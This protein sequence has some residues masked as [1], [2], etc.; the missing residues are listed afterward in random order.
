MK[1]HSVA[2]RTVWWKYFYP[3]SASVLLIAVSGSIWLCLAGESFFSLT[4]RLP[5]EVLV[6]EGW[7]GQDGARAAATE[8]KDGGYQYIVATGG[9]SEEELGNSNYAEMAEQALIALGVPK[10]RIIAAPI[11]PVERQRTFTSAVA[12]WQALEGKRV[13]PA[14]LNVFT[15]GPHAR[16]SRLIYAKVCRPG[17]QVGVIAFVPPSY[18]AKPWWQS[19]ERA[20]CLLKE[21]IGYPFEALL[22]SGRAAYSPG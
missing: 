4:S 2:R 13:H 17:T 15:L 20:Q 9:Q 6:V 19:K 18:A 22:N 16:R 10:D 5:A 12:A 1:S 3:L 21:V 8:F 7:I 11:G 14:A